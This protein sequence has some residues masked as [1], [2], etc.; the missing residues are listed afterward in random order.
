MFNPCAYC[1]NY[2]ECELDREIEEYCF[3][4]SLVDELT[5]DD[6]IDAIIEERRAE[7]RSEWFSY[8]NRDE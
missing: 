1:E 2:N 5:E 6:Y 7:F 8:I 4:F 3:N